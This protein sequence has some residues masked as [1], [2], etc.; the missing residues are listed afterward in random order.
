MSSYSAPG[1]VNWDTVH[2]VRMQLPVLAQELEQPRRPRII[3]LVL[4]FVFVDRAIEGSRRKML[5]S[6]NHIQN[7][8]TIGVVR[9]QKTRRSFSHRTLRALFHG[10][11]IE[12][13]GS[14]AMSAVA[15]REWI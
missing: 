11:E 12:R 8:S 15:S 14:H 9:L 13:T 4:Q 3:Q 6:A 5:R 10:R 1:K 7:G 2:Q